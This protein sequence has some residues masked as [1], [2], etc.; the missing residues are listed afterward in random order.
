MT[1]PMVVCGAAGRMGRTLVTLIAQNDAAALVGAVEAG[2]HA[3]LGKDAGEV[4]GVGHL[5]VAITEDFAAAA[6]PDA[7][8][9]DFTSAAAALEHLRL[10]V[11]RRSPIVIGSTGFTAQ[12]QAEMDRLAPQTRCVI[13]PNMSVGIAVLQQLIRAAA[14]ALGPDFD[15]EIVEMHHRMKVDAPSG[16]ALALGKTVAQATGRDFSADAVFG[17]EGVVGQRQR[18][19]IGILALRGGD[20]VG[21]HTVIFAG[22]G[23]RIELTH[24]AQSRECLA[25]GAIR[26]ALWLAQQPLGRYSMSDVLG[27]R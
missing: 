20:V 5:G 6:S 14:I 25:R 26:A 11:E 9:L 10:A 22:L 7:V 27:V 4:A 2:G 1:T 13:A 21:D 19:E 3:A 12:Q 23:E 17:R 8:T 16:T 24:R 15:P 18:K